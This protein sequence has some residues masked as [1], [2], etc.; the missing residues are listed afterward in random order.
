MLEKR[1]IVRVAGFHIRERGEEVLAGGH[2]DRIGG[3]G[4]GT[5]GLDA[6]GLWPPQ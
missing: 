6:T 5:D 4:C 1:R 2:L 3:V